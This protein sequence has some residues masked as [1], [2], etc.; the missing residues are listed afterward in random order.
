[1]KEK[2]K[3]KGKFITTVIIGDSNDGDYVD[4][5]TTRFYETEEERTSIG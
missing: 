5:A 1:M 2:I 4:K 3:N